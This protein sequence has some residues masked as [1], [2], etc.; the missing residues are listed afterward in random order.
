M[1][2]LPAERILIEADA[3][4]PGAAGA[5][6]PTPPNVNTVNL[7]DNVVRLGLAPRQILA[8]HGPRIATLADLRAAAGK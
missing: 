8:L 4:T 3:Y 7:Y 1:V 2:W 5:P 6:A